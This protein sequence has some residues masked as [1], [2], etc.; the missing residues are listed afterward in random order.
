M[1]NVIQMGAAAE[2]IPITE[3][4]GKTAVNLRDLHAFL[5]VKKDFT[6]WA[7]QMFEYGF[8]EHEDY[9][10]VSLPKNGSNPAA[11][12]TSAIGRSRSTWPKSCR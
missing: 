3:Y 4:Q 7:K 11:A 10:E 2:L 1:N 12:R 5:E 9:L 8:T 6:D